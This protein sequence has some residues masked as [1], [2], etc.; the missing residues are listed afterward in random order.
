[1]SAPA[2]NLATR[3]DLLTLR[4]DLTNELRAEIERSARRVIM[5]TSSMVV[6]TAGLAFA[7]GKFI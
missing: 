6:A 2:T 3:Q 5:W 1:M 4:N 7:A